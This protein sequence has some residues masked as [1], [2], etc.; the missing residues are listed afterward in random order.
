L[1]C[2]II[3]RSFGDEIHEQALTIEKIKKEKKQLQENLNKS[4]EDI[5]SSESKNNHLNNLITKLE[6]SLDD[7]EDELQKGKKAT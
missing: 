6:H 2:F 5:Q 4:F 3:E 7:L 1:E